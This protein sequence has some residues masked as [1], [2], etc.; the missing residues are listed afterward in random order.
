MIFPEVLTEVLRITARPDKEAAASLAINK[1]I[2]Y[3]SIKGDFPADLVEATLAVSPT[4]Y[5]DTIS[6]TPLLNFRK[7]KYVK[8]TGVR[9]YLLPIGEDKVFTPSGVIQTDRYYL[10]G[11]S[12]TYTLSALT[13]SLEV[14]YLTYPS[15]LD[16]SVH[17]THWMLDIIPYAIIDKACADLFITVGDESSARAHL[18]QAMEQYRMF[19]ADLVI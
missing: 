12:M 9:Y 4:L 19:Q 13:P 10:A 15:L 8:P 18:S 6:L 17:T 11:T 14:G 16:K 7:F 1:A 5:G 3:F 2:S